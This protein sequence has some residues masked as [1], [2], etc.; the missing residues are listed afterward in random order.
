MSTPHQLLFGKAP[1]LLDIKVFGCLCY[2]TTLTQNRKKLDPRA[3]KCCFLGFK[4]GTKGYVLLDLQ[5]RDIFISRNVVF[6]EIVFL[7]TSGQSNIVDLEGNNLV[8][9]DHNNFF[10]DPWPM[11]VTLPTL[12]RSPQGGPATSPANTVSPIDPTVSTE[13]N[14]DNQDLVPTPPTVWR[15]SR[16]SRPP[17]R[18]SNYCI[19]SLKGSSSSA[20]TEPR[21]PLSNV[22]CYDNIFER[23][24]KYIMNISKDIEPSS[25]VAASTDPRWIEAMN[26]ELFAL[27]A[28]N[29]WDLLQL[30]KNKK[31]I[32]SKW[33]YKIKYKANG[34]IERY[35]A[36]LL[37]KG[38]N[39]KEG[40]LQ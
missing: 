34:E 32:G 19:Y 3:R 33:V 21:Y 27:A 39:Q 35:K 26:A 6:K 40:R 28:N 20:T 9:P 14:T 11:E 13:Q 1:A 17:E 7:F 30:P 25:Y 10:Y 15:S 23:Y 24:S 18:L 22:L 16:I 37:A 8:F 5:N 2:A 29:T 38:Y 4:N 31:A 36:R 12:S